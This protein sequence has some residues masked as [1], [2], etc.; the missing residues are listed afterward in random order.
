[1]YIELLKLTTYLT[2]NEYNEI[3]IPCL[4]V[5]KS[6][7]STLKFLFACSDRSLSSFVRSSPL[8]VF[9]PAVLI[10]LLFN[11]ISSSLL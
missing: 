10:F 7:S 6:S 9:P 5:S 4:A 8:G 11:P 2:S 3:V 1:M